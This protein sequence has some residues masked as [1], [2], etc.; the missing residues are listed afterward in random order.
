MRPGCTVL[1][2]FVIGWADRQTGG[3]AAAEPHTVRV[4]A[5]R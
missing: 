3:L 4:T 1:M 5:T 2:S